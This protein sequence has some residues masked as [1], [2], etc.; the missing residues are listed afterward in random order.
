MSDDYYCG[1]DK[2]PKGKIRGTARQCLDKNQV[3]Y[4][5]IEEIPEKY[6]KA[7]SEAKKGNSLQKELLKQKKLEDKAKAL[8]KESKNLNLL[9]DDDKLTKRKRAALDKKKEAL[10]K[11]RDKLI[12]AIKKQKAVVDAAKENKKA[13]EKI[14]KKKTKKGG[15]RKYGSKTSKRY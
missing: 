14:K 10:L 1:I 8:I 7:K 11:R 13:E 15:S 5:G 9:L 4:Y 12:A 2:V 6:L 3:R